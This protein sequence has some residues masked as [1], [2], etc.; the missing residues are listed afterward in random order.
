MTVDEYLAQ[1]RNLGPSDRSYE[2][3]PR[4]LKFFFKL[5]GFI[6]QYPDQ[7]IQITTL[8]N[9]LLNTTTEQ[10]K[11]FIW[12]S[13]F[14]Q[15]GLEGRDGEIS[16]PYRI[17]LRLVNTFPGIET[18]KLML[19][20]EAENDSEEEFERITNLSRLSLDEIISETGTTPAMAANAVKIL[21]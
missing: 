21:P 10:N 20:L 1:Q 17:L 5:L 16:H 2:T 7:H 14:L 6:V 8:G 4:D 19:A 15:I 11:L 13:A 9:E 18:K 3:T 12:K